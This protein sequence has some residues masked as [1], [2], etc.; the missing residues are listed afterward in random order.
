MS[1]TLANMLALKKQWSKPKLYAIKSRILLIRS[2]ML[3][4]NEV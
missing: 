2:L 1:Y 4:M 3:V